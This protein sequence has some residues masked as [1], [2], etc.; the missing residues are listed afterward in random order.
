MPIQFVWFQMLDNG[1][2]SFHL[3]EIL[4]GVINKW[5]SASYDHVQSC[6]VGSSVVN[7]FQSVLI[8]SFTYN[9]LP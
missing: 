3:M 7:G 4:A 9:F 5:C 1:V 6:C 8:Y 2:Y